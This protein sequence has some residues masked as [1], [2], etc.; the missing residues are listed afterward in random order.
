MGQ[1]QLCT[2][3]Y[4]LSLY[5]CDNGRMEG[6]KERETERITEY[7]FPIHT[8]FILLLTGCVSTRIVGA[9]DCNV[10]QAFWGSSDYGEEGTHGEPLTVSSD[11]VLDNDLCSQIQYKHWG[12]ELR[13][14]ETKGKICFMCKN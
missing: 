10:G 13:K 11:S 2:Y 12:K 6:G 5:A 3:C 14:S 7:V 1:L 9:S 8:V 4:Y